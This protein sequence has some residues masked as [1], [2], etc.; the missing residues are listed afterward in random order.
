MK[1]SVRVWWTT[2]LFWEA[3]EATKE[4]I[5]NEQAKQSSVSVPVVEESASTGNESE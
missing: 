1:K 4:R 5:A 2:N 3:Y